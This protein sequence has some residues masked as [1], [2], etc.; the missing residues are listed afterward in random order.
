MKDK[1]LLIVD[2]EVNV[3]NALSRLLRN[4]VYEVICIQNPLEVLGTLEKQCVSVIISDQKMPDIKGLD[5]LL[6]IKTLYPDI[7]RVILS[8]HADINLL[9]DSINKEIVYRFL[10]KPWNDT[11]VKSVIKQC[12]SHYDLNRRNREVLEG[13]H[14]KEKSS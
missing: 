14:N 10:T 1:K 8:A 3:L 5:L 12:M 6:K 2:D 13:F 7:V 4:E 9:I 11:E